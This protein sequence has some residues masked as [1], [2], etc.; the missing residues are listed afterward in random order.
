MSGL[1]ID[2]HN[3]IVFVIRECSMPRINFHIYKELYL[4]SLRTNVSTGLR[5]V[6][7][8]F[9]WM[10]CCYARRPLLRNAIEIDLFNCSCE[11]D[12]QHTLKHFLTR[13]FLSLVL[14]RELSLVKTVCQFSVLC[15]R[16]NLNSLLNR[17]V[18]VWQ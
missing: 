18:I 9:D 11:S 14:F 6:F 2:E 17:C 12:K 8:F 15:M 4:N 3:E 13:F 5:F 16:H 1:T 10:N 7:F